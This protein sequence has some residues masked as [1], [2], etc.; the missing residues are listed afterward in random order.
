MLHQKLALPTP[1]HRKSGHGDG[2]GPRADVAV[3]DWHANSVGLSTLRVLHG[4]RQAR[5]A[6]EGRSRLERVAGNSAALA[7]GVD[8][9]RANL[10]G[11]DLSGAVLTPPS[12]L[13]HILA[14]PCPGASGQL[15]NHL[16][17]PDEAG[18]KLRTATAGARTRLLTSMCG[19]C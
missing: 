19:R 18:S 10:S 16:A 8:L 13:R 15:M 4:E 2:L 14:R 17:T 11:A 9:I 1:A 7:K 5:V 12:G 6:Q 3:T